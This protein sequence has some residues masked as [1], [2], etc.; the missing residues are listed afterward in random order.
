MFGLGQDDEFFSVHFGSLFIGIGS[1]D[2]FVEF[3]VG[4]EDGSFFDSLGT[5]DLFDENFLRFGF[6]ESDGD[7][8]GS[9][10]SSKGFGIEDFLLF[11]DHGLLN[12]DTLFDDVLDFLFL[13]FHRFVFLDGF[14]LGDAEAFD[15]F[16]LL[17]ALDTL[18][19]DTIGAFLIALCDEN[20]TLFVFL[21]DL[22][23]LLGADAGL[24][25][26]LAFFFLHL[27]GVGLFTGPD[28]VDLALLLGF[29]FGKLA[30]KFEDG[31]A[32]FD[33]LLLD[34]LLFIAKN[35]VG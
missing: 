13:N 10:G 4:F 7:L 20:L 23:F 29:G 9:V 28:D 30:F 31:L 19:F 5:F 17:V 27:H 34:D 26:L 16:E 33:V 6:G 24:F 15:L 25:C 35:V 32:S 14:D 1:F 12:S 22:D 21:G 3:L 18:E 2:A 11:D 8:F